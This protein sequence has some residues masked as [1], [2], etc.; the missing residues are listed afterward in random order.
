MPFA[1][2][3]VRAGS[4]IRAWVCPGVG[5]SG[6]QLVGLNSGI[7]PDPDMF[8]CHALVGNAVFLR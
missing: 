2:M 1:G 4:G 8:V 6:R 7:D 3:I 5:L